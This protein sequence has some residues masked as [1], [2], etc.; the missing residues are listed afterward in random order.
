[1]LRPPRR[2]RLVLATTAVLALVA[3]VVGGPVAQLMKTGRDNFDDRGSESAQAREALQDAAGISPEADLVVLVDTPSGAATGAGRRAI[4][5]AVSRLEESD[6][7]ASVVAPDVG[8]GGPLVASD[9][10]SVIVTASFRPLDGQDAQDAALRIASELGGR[11][12]LEFGGPLLASAEIREQVTDDLRRAELL[13]FPVLFA[14][15]LFVF[16]GLIAALL[17]ILVGAL[18][19][20]GTLLA[21]RAAAAVTDLS[22]FALNLVT[23]LGLGLAIDYSLFILTRFR[24][25]AALHGH[26]RETMQRTLATAGRTVAF[27]S[28][29]V[30]LALATLLVFP[31]RFLFSMGLGGAL[32]AVV[33]A[34][35][36]LVALP[37]A[38]M[39]LGPRVDALALRRTPPDAQSRWGRL[40]RAVTRRP[41][42]LGG[43]AAVVLLAIAA[44]A[45]DVR[46]TG[47]DATILP[48]E[49]NA[50]QVAD[51]IATDYAPGAT[52][53][54]TVA[55][56]GQDAAVDRVRHRLVAQ[57][58]LGAVGEA[59][60]IGPSLARVD[61]IVPAVPLSDRGQE[62]VDDIRDALRGLPA[63][64]TGEAARFRDAQHALG[65]RL[66]IALGA[67]TVT[68]IAI[69]FVMTGGLPVALGALLMNALT[70]AAAFGALVLIFQEGRFEGLL[71]YTSQGALDA[72]QMVLLFVLV[73]AL[74]T[75][76]GVFLLGRIKEERDRGRSSRDA[77]VEGLG[78]TGRLITAAALL[79]CI[80]IGAFATSEIVFIKEVGLGT[81]LAVLVD[82][83]LIRGLLLPALLAGLGDRAWWPRAR[84][85][86]RDVQRG[87]PVPEANS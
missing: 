40:G 39:L 23:G 69:L 25:E 42:L 53:P 82:A 5:G 12:D 30:A 73:F 62:M 70:V 22:I 19:V 24:E 1:M 14:L 80:A 2:P 72:A 50:R 64:V 71:D 21:L 36:A 67:L 46:F 34:A 74:S 52:T 6:V 85:A 58:H 11:Q 45:L 41:G 51:R 16:R 59:E 35:V 78:A 15:S 9:G 75:D 13:A 28:A 18:A 29:I 47:F 4:A 68:T 86:R 48:F 43:A 44:P 84:G 54:V 31:Q 87:R 49:A 79:F 7:V 20:L 55:V 65:E 32:V 17:P 33:A 8:A 38:L 81:A 61:V 63:Q 27:S 56:E 60:R 76:Y 77:I 83:T 26:G 66:P 3:L 10:R 37:A 57:D